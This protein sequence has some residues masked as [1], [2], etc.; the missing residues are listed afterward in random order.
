MRDPRPIAAEAPYTFFLP[1]PEHV[2]AVQ[3]GDLV[4]AIFSDRDGG[5]DAERM[6]VTVERVMADHF[7][8]TLSNAPADMQNLAEGEP[9]AIP[10]SHL[11]AI[12]PG[13]NR[14]LPDVERP[15]E[16][17][18][19]CMVDQCVLDGRSKVDYLYREPAD[20]D[21]EGD[22]DPDSGWRLR[23]T[24]AGIAEDEA[25]GAAPQYVA[26]GAVLNRDDRWLGLIDEPAGFA[27]HWQDDTGEFTRYDRADLLDNHG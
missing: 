16:H 10:Q 4:K 24:E 8:G 1:P 6:W 11:I 14:A 21:R 5:H 19:R 3:S 7:V 9:V 27:W 12:L 25:H 26:L 20:M 17:W 2:D 13:D 22:A 18:E 15:R 23:G